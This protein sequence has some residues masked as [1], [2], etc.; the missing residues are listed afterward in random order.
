MGLVTV[1]RAKQAPGL[2]NVNSSYL[3]NLINAASTYIEASGAPA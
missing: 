1:N 2:T 3:S